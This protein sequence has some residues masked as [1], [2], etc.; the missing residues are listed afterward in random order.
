MASS[1]TL[2]SDL[3]GGGNGP[4]GDEDLVKRIFADMNGGGGG[5]QM[6]MSP[7]PNTTAPMAMDS[8][9][10]TSHVIG[11]DHPTPGDFAAAM[12]QASRVQQTYQMPPPQGA[13]MPQGPVQGQW[14]APY[15]PQQPQ[16]Y[17]EPPKKNIYAKVAEEIKIPIFVALLVFVFSLPFLN[18]LFQ[19]YIPSLVKPTGDLTTIG[20]LGK[21]VIAGATFWVLQRIV[22]P[23]ISL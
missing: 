11:K 6:I 12:H 7:N 10:Q 13:G 22:V 15:Q 21:S 2:L 14:G 3:G 23:L 20:L 1:G 19:H 5:N 9:P 18:I 8:G 17:A 4:S 16:Q